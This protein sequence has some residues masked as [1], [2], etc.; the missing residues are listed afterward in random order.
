MTA[1]VQ[2]LYRNGRRLAKASKAVVGDLNLSVGKNPGSGA[3]CSEACLLTETGWSALP[4]LYDAVCV[5]IAAHGLRLRGV[6]IVAS[7]AVAQE[8]WCVL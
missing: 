5:V 3:L 8:W 1:S 7:R 2:T 4:P 6:E